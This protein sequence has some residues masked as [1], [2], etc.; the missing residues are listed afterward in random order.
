[1]I[2][3][4]LPPKGAYIYILFSHSLFTDKNYVFFY[5]SQS[6]NVGQLTV[7]LL[8]REEE[9]SHQ[10]SRQGMKI[11]RINMSCCPPDGQ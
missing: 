8:Q 3:Q 4:K 1:M 10:T 9:S 5:L 7:P 2:Q 6:T 11:F